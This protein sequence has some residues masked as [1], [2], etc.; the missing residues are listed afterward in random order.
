MKV[1]R[2]ITDLRAEI[3]RWRSA[4]ETVALVPT[5]GAL[6]AG[7]IALV[8]AGLAIADRV[9]VSIF[10]NP[11]QFAPHEDLAR[12]PRDEAG[13][14]SKLAGAGAHLVWA[15]SVADMYP[16]GFATQIVAGGAALPLEGAFRP[17]HFGGVATVVCKLVSAVTP[18]VALF[19]EKDFQQLAVIRQMVRDL[20][21][22]VTIQGVP[23]VREEDGLALSSRNAYLSDDERYIAPMLYKVI[24]EVARGRD[25]QDAGN[26]LLAAGFSKIDY[27]EVRDAETLAPFAPGSGRPGRV[28]AAVWLGKTRL[29]D[30]VAI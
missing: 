3:A 15:P 16:E 7:H 6:H 4:G 17:H 19:G 20:A 2:T 1:V 13:D 22:P 23:T 9:V 21:L 27:I 10:V 24:S 29:I 8:A 26:A 14:V 25:P 12:Y 30:N 11:T 28:L 18:N 5:M